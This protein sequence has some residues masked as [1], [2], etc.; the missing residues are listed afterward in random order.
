M[1]KAITTATA[2]LTAA[3]LLTGCGS[4]SKS[5]DA[6]AP[7]QASSSASG[8]PEQAAGQTHQVTLEVKGSGKGQ[9]VWSAGDNG[10]D[11]VDL[12]WKKQTTVALKGAELKLGTPL[13]VVPQAVQDSGGRFVFPACTITVDG[14]QV[15]HNEDKE[16]AKGCEYL[17]KATP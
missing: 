1:R 14:K 17:L 15:A 6:K 16:N 9:V 13:S 10:M 4:G 3:V 2:L 12:P 8:T 5:P 7:S 11:Q